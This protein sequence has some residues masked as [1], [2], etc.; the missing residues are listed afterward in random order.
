MINKN[1]KVKIYEGNKETDDLTGLI[2]D[3]NIDELK[4]FNHNFEKFYYVIEGLDIRDEKL[5][6]KTIKRLNMSNH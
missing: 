4:K 6:D 2:F 1:D 5:F 3:V